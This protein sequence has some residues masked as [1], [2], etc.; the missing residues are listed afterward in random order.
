MTEREWE[1]STDVSAMLSALRT[2]QS[3]WQWSTRKARLFACACCRRVWSVLTEQTQ[4]DAVEAAERAADKQISLADLAVVQKATAALQV[5]IRARAYGGSRG[6]TS[7]GDWNFFVDFTPE[8]NLFCNPGGKASVPRPWG[9]PYGSANDTRALLHFRASSEAARSEQRA[10]CELLRDIVGPMSPPV[11]NE[12][13]L[14]ANDRTTERLALAIYAERIFDGLP[15]LADALEDSGCVD[16]I[17]LS[18]LRGPGPHCRGC[19]AM[20]QLLA[21]K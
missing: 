18:H 8:N 16:Q 19:W 10:Q 3:P 2:R 11:V 21:R 6:Q 1:D 20:D 12:A 9:N 14:A 13:W 7:Q 15:V 4:R 17:L 5:G